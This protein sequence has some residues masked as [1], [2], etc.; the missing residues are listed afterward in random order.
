MGALHFAT[1]SYTHLDVYKRQVDL[2]AKS[3][4]SSYLCFWDDERDK[5]LYFNLG[6]GGE[7]TL[8]PEE[9]NDWTGKEVIWM[10]TDNKDKE[11]KDG[12]AMAIVKDTK[13]QSLS[14]IHI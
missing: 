7:I 2:I 3:Q 10:G 9:Y 13:D 8:F 5:F 6:G 1:V 14:L 12:I 4:K 11:H